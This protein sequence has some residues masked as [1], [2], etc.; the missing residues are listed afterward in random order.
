MELTEPHRVTRH[1]VS[2]AR[3]RTVT[4]REHARQSLVMVAIF[5]AR[6]ELPERESFRG[7]LTR[8]LKSPAFPSQCANERKWRTAVVP[9]T[10]NNLQRPCF[11]D[12]I[13]SP[14]FITCWKDLSLKPRVGDFDEA[15]G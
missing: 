14:R 6:L 15:H 7:V 11:P 9:A 5:G 3:L 10:P 1:L 13:R 12:L 4:A 8:S 2:P